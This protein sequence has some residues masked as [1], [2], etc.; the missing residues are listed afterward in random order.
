MDR[1]GFLRNAA[2]AVAAGAVAGCTLCGVP[3]RQARSHS[4]ARRWLFRLLRASSCT[5][6]AVFRCWRGT[7]WW[8]VWPGP[9]RRT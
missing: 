4:R 8:A 6:P 9:P 2:G 5:G 1:R 7:R 3:G